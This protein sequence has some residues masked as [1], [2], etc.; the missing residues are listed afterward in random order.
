M[1][2]TVNWSPLELDYLKENRNKI[3][4]SQ[5]CI[6][7]AKSKNAINHKLA[8]FDGKQVKKLNKIKIGKRKDCNNIFFR[9]GWESNIFRWLR[10]KKYTNIEYEPT[11]FSFLHFGIRK[12]TVTYTP[13]FKVTKIDG[14]YFWIEVKG[15]LQ[16]DDKTR[17]RRFKKFYPDEF[18]HL[19]CIPGSEK[20]VAAKF[21]QDLGVPILTTY[22]NLNKKYKK[23]IANWE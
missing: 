8:E 21:F 5:L 7:L 14:S 17:L 4:I 23:V 11:D 20:T 1:R 6:T 12:G 3:T 10:Y 2:R 13:D 9:S 19:V 16:S 18:Q 15:Q 22:L